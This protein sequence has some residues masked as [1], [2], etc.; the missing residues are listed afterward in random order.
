MTILALI[1]ATL[2]IAYVLFGKVS[3]DNSH[4]HGLS[5]SNRLHLITRWGLHN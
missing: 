1:G 5:D 4:S 3:E 2:L